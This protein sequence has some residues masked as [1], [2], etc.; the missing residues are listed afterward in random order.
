MR[1]SL[2]VL[3]LL[4]SRVHG[5]QLLQNAQP[6][7]CSVQVGRCKPIASILSS[8]APSSVKVSMGSLDCSFIYD[9]QF[10]HN[11]V[12]YRWNGRETVEK[13]T[14]EGVLVSG[15]MDQTFI[16]MVYSSQY[17]NANAFSVSLTEKRDNLLKTKLISVPCYDSNVRRCTWVIESVPVSKQ[18]CDNNGGCANG[19]Q[20]VLNNKG[21]IWCK[22][23]APQFSGSRCE[24]VGSAP[25]P[26]APAPAPAAP[27]P[28]PPAPVPAPSAPAPTLPMPQP[29]APVPAPPAPV[30]APPAPRPQPP[31]PVPPAPVPQ[32]PAPSSEQDVYLK[33]HNDA[34]AAVGVQAV[35]WSTTVAASAQAYANTCPS[36]HSGSKYG[37]NLAWMGRGTTQQAVQMWIDEKSA[38]SYGSNS[39]A[40][41]KVCGHYTQIVW[42]A[43]TEIGCAKATCG[44]FAILGDASGTVWVCQYSPPGNYVG[45]PPY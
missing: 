7:D 2:S 15:I 3:S 11:G 26:P 42:R 1:Y 43:T 44:S 36:D 34:R 45:R 17:C 25:Q 29:P 41:G 37:E 38:Y 16:N 30:P 5:R 4:L 39:C 22:N 24:I 10:S 12:T 9:D 18:T 35:T 33:A 23:C 27:M 28:Q 13:K 40:P 32:P 14:R 8:L 6:V 20:C 19:S 21:L 31:A